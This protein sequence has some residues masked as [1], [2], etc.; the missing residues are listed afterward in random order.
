MKQSKIHMNNIIINM[1]R[2]SAVSVATRYGPDGTGIESLWWRDF[3]HPSRPA[4][5][6]T[7]SPIQWIPTLSRG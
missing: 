1:G 7:E 4:L 6:P 5:G 2:D 3:P